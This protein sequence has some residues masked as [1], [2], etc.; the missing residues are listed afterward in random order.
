MENHGLTAGC[1]FFEE[2]TLGYPYGFEIGY[3]QKLLYFTWEMMLKASQS[4]RFV[5]LYPILG[6]NMTQLLT[7][8]THSSSMDPQTC[9][10][11]QK[12]VP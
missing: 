12:Q 11:A 4:A 5:V 7:A 10:S 9:P 3:A 8:W 2:L 6:P 1:S